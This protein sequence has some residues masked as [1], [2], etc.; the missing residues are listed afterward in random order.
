M[1]HSFFALGH[2]NNIALFRNN[3]VIAFTGLL[4]HTRMD[5][6]VDS[7]CFMLDSIKTKRNSKSTYTYTNSMGHLLSICAAGPCSL[8]MVYKTEF[9]SLT[10]G[11]A[12]THMYLAASATHDCYVFLLFTYECRSQAPPISGVRPPR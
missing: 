9:N 2:R 12:S 3:I 7:G 4:Q 10:A 11:L 5:I 8:T 1:R 6:Y